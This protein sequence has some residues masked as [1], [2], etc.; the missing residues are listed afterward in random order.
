MTVKV[1]TVACTALLLL[2][3]GISVFASNTPLRLLIKPVSDRVQSIRFQT[4]VEETDR[5]TLVPASNPALVLEA[6]D[7]NKDR[8]FVQQSQD[9]Q[10]WSSSYEYQYNPVDKSWSIVPLKVTIKPVSY[11]IQSIRFQTGADET[12]I[13]TEVPA[14]NP[15]LVLEE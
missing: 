14:S 6:F 9:N 1:R 8:L 12:D 10:V 11:R 7:S 4:G 2:F 13:W 5:W 15:A 3:S